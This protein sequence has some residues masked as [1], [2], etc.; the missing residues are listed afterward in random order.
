MDNAKDAAQIKPLIPPDGCMFLVTSRIHFTLPGLYQKD[1]NTFPPADATRFLLEIA[2]RIEGEA[3][4]IAKLCGYLALALRL[5][6]TAIAERADLD[7]A[8]YRQRLADEKQRLKLLG[9]K[10]EEG[11]E[12]SITLSYNLLDDDRKKQWRMLSVFPDTF[13]PPAAAAV[14]EVEEDAAKETLSDLKQLSLLEWDESTK[15][16]RLHDLMRTFARGKLDEDEDDSEAAAL[17]HARHYLEVIRTAHQLYMEGGKSMMR[18]LALFDLEWGNIQAGQAWSAAHAGSNPEAATLCSDY[19][20]RAA[21]LLSLRQHPRGRIRWREAALAAARKLKDREG[22]G[23]HLGSLGIAYGL[24]GEHLRAIEY[25]EQVLAIARETSDRRGEGQ[26]LGNLGITYKNLGEHHRAIE[27][28]EKALAIDR[29][30]GDR[31]GEG[32]DLGNLGSAY[33]SLG[34][35]QRALQYYQQ[36]LAI[37]REIGDKRGE[38]NALQG[39]GIVSK[40]LGE[41]DSALEVFEQQLRT[42]RVIGDQLGEGA[43]LWNMSLAVE[44]R[45]DRKAAVEH[46]EA[47][48]KIFEQIEDP[49]AAIVKQQLDAWRNG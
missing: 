43:A 14:W 45:G 27:Y 25:F 18:G 4:S 13:D 9:G 20:D 31:R 10:K 17:R 30:I 5:A 8:D 36:R 23:V 39:L 49:K 21:Y 15:R 38:G 35:H 32:Q 47:A 19:P 2:P 3:E 42:T 26:A 33:Y 48:L 12:A 24:L 37:A 6:G 1:L 22:E 44:E 41:I 46:A 11:V 7:P 16:Y 29:E 28:H 34:D 40:A